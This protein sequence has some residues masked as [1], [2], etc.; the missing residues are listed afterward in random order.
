[1]KAKVTVISPEQLEAIIQE[2]FPIFELNEEDEEERDATIEEIA[3]AQA[4]ISFKAGYQQGYTRARNH[5]EDVLLPLERVAGMKEVGEWVNKHN[6]FYRFG[7]EDGTVLIYAEDWQA[8]LK[9]VET[10]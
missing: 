7:F 2:R 5:C 3:K 10:W 4:E 6:K 1:M 8:F 9:E